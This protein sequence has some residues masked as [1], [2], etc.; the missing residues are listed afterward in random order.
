MRESYDPT[1]NS[2]NPTPLLIKEVRVFFRAGFKAKQ[3]RL[4]LSTPLD[5]PLGIL[6]PAVCPIKQNR[7][8][9]AVDA[10][11]IRSCQRLHS[12][13]AL[14]TRQTMSAA[15]QQA[16]ALQ[17]MRNE[18]QAQGQRDL[19][20]KMTEKCFAKCAAN[21]KGGNRLERGEQMCVGMCVDRYVDV[22][23]CVNEALVARQRDRS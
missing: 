23:N 2:F 22:M 17:Q 12:T 20:T 1:L 11:R 16:A 9:P 5:T 18:V 8:A 14:V 3:V 13:R 4:L 6:P 15:E 21:A 19:M 7:C 10:C